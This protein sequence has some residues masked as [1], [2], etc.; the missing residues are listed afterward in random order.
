MIAIM[1]QSLPRKI[2]RESLSQL[3]KEE[4]VEIV[5]QQAI[6]ISELQATIQELKT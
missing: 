4:L 2:D 1:N 6:A 5:I 3:F